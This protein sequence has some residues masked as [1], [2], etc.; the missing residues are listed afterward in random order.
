MEPTLAGVPAPIDAAS[1]TDKPISCGQDRTQHVDSPAFHATEPG[2]AS[3]H[4]GHWLATRT[5]FELPQQI[6]RDLMDDFVLVSHA[7]LTACRSACAMTAGR[8]ASGR[9]GRRDP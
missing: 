1:S 9:S 7:A 4:T 5:A 2:R 8:S 3:R 6:V